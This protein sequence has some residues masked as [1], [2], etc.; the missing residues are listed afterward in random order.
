MTKDPFT[1][2]IRPADP[3]RAVAIVGMGCLFP[4]ADDLTMY[5]ANICNRV[6]AIT[7]VPPTHWDPESYYSADPKAPD[8]TYACRGGFLSPVDFDPMEFG[9][10]PNAIEATDSTQLLGLIVA[11]QALRDAGYGPGGREFD[12]KRVSCIL[13]VTGTLGLVIPLGARL[14]HPI[15]RQALRDAGV[16]DDVTEDVVRRI[17]ESYVP[18]QEASFPGLLGNVVAGRIANHLDLGGTNCVVDAACASALSAVE[19]AAMELAMGRA[20]MAITG[21]MD[22]F[23]DIFMYMC[24]SK[25]PALSPTGDARP[26]DHKADGTTL[27]E[28]LG[29]AVLKRLEDAERDGD[30]IYAVI[31][32]IGSSSDGKG[33]AIYAPSSEGQA[34]ALRRA[35]EVAGMTPDTIELVEAH[36]TGTVAGDTAEIASLTDVYSQFTDP[37]RVN[38]KTPWCALGAVKSQIGHTKAA[39]GMAGLIKI[40]LALH[41]KVLPPT[42]KVEK[43]AEP[44]R[45]NR[46]AFYVNTEKRPWL[47]RAEHPRRAAVSSFGFGGSNFHCLLEEHGNQKDHVDWDGDVQILAF[48]AKSPPALAKTIRAFSAPPKWDDLRVCAAQLRAAFR[49]DDPCRLLIVAEREKTDLAKLLEDACARLES[50]DPAGIHGQDARATSLTLTDPVGVR[51]SLPGGAWYGSGA[52]SGKLAALFPGQ[53][54]TRTGM[55]RDLAC[56]FPEMLDA[57]AEAN[58]AFPLGSVAQPP[59]AVEDAARDPSDGLTDAV[60]RRLSDLIFPVPAFDAET[61]EANQQVLRATNVAQPAIGVVSMGALGVLARFGVEPEAFAGH[62]YGELP[63]LCAAGRFDSRALHRLSVLRGRLMASSGGEAK[64][65]MLAVRAGLETVERVIEE[66]K[67]DLTVANKNAPN[68]FVLSGTTK[69]IDKAA[70]DFGER[71]VSATRLSVPAAF[72]SA[73]M[74]PARGPFLEALQEVRFSRARFPVFSNVTGGEY[75]AAP[76]KARDLLASQLASPVEFVREIENMYG[77]GVRTFLEVGPGATLT[78]LVQAILGKRDHEAIALDASRGKRSGMADLA[79]ALAQLAALGHRVE[80]AQWD[81]DC[82]IPGPKRE[83]RKPVLT[84]SVCGANYVRSRP[85]E[86]PVKQGETDVTPPAHSGSRTP[87]AS[88]ERTAHGPHPPAPTASGVAAFAAPPA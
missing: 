57:L 40:A 9:I 10:P 77:L 47:P 58:Q 35:Y 17:S 22:A 66:A 29:V 19:M 82:I 56:V 75:P 44:L 28:G 83:R 74:T 84:I 60:G 12:R 85:F 34:L 13:G 25:T 78:G 72:H 41:H 24:F 26:F 86:P 3:I 63:A 53:G 23:N 51:W 48:S 62:S 7:E 45:N 80:L 32:G 43:P 87:S 5:W 76:R 39:A 20:D 4:K 33:L 42:I 14:G 31:R 67:L 6:D 69:E 50:S 2:P 15:W 30:R 1:D 38:G 65:A 46:T 81:G 68:Q 70:G 88:R 59:P 64:G 11:R 27:G 18:W 54:G 36:G 49:I 71:G 79:R 73:H 16:A 21:G 37:V 52:P 55:M 61:A 8:M